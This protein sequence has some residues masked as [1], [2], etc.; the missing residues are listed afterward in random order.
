MFIYIQ[1][2]YKPPRIETIKHTI[3]QYYKDDKQIY[4]ISGMQEKLTL[5]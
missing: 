4:K 3:S 1:T 2:K 5:K